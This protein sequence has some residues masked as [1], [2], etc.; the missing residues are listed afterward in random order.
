MTTGIESAPSTKW[1]WAGGRHLSLLLLVLYGL[2]LLAIRPAT[3]FE[4]DE[5][6]FQRALDHYDV[7]VHSPHPPGYPVYIAAARPLR[8]V[9]GDPLL[10]LQLVAVIS[11]VVTLAFVWRLSHDLGSP[12]E[13]A[14]AASALLAM[15]PAFAFNANVG[16]SDLAGTAAAVTTVFFLVRS[17][18]APALLPVAAVVSALAVGVRP[19]LVVALFPVGAAA[20]WVAVRARRWRTLG[21]S[22][23]VGVAATVACWAPAIVIT[24]PGRFWAAVR[25][26]GRWVEVTERGYHLPGA[27]LGDVLG[28]W[29]LRPFGPTALGV[30]VWA[31]VV[32]GS[33]RWIRRGNRRLVAVAAASAV[34]YLVV[35]AWSMN[36]TTSVRYGLPALPFLAILAA[37]SLTGPSRRSR[38]AAGAVVVLWCVAAIVWTWPALRER[39]KPAPLWGALTWVREHFNPAWTRVGFEGEAS[40]HVDYVLR[41]A[42]FRTFQ[43]GQRPAYE[44]PEQPGEQTILVTARPIPDTEVLYQ[45]RYSKRLVDDLARGRYGSCAVS[46]VEAPHRAVLS[47]E[48]RLVAQGLRLR[49][50]GQIRFVADPAPALVRV[51]AGGDTI[52]VSHPGTPGGAL[53]A[54]QCELIPLL[55]GRE[56]E[57]SVSAPPHTA[58]TIPPIQRFPLAPARGGG[59]LTSAYMVPQVAHVSGY[60]GARWR[61][62][63]V[64]INPQTHSLH[65]AAAFLP[66][67]RDNSAAPWVTGT[68]D[69]GHVLDL[70]DV[71]TLPE[72][73]GR[74]ALGA[75]LIHALGPGPGCGSGER[76]F[77]V[78]ARTYN[79]D[80]AQDRWRAGELLPGV[81]P[82]D[83][84]GL[85]DSVAFTRVTNT[86]VEGASVGLAA[87]SGRPMRVRIEVFDRTGDRC[88]LRVVQLAPF[89]HVRVPLQARFA[90]GT[91]TVEP[92]GGARGAIAFPYIALVDRREGLPTYRLPEVLP[93]HNL[94]EG[95]VPPMPLPLSKAP[96]HE[97]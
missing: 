1:R 47:P 18:E 45:A 10:A 86:G 35:A 15:T 74:G 76:R 31:L 41:R 52:T 48:W 27:P 46:R 96:R 32:W 16:L 30:V 64:V 82:V 88:E 75:L 58:T 71:L 25:Q 2:L 87:W 59:R 70:P 17:L 6:L 77:L 4:W 66:S 50:T 24:G 72:F 85:G 29:L 5:V 90:D 53:S 91:V 49:G 36:F 51:C 38:R 55:P 43:I 57:I 7:A 83:G 3:P 54:R 69:A 78:L 97:R 92:I 68:L 81:A 11:A 93:Q 9:V 95:W 63:L 14:F 21:A 39:L 73:K 33:W 62:E 84:I 12:W 40:P 23:A 44:S 22:F 89:G 65:I 61:T 19:Q 67:G 79:L 37:G 80:A 8:A 56:G 20:V 94:P 34:T 42:G 28:A 60:A 26:Q 13:A